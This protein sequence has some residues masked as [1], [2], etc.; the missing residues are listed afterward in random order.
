MGSNFGFQRITNY[1]EYVHVHL[2]SVEVG[3]IRGCDLV[4]IIVVRFNVSAYMEELGTCVMN[5][6]PGDSTGTNDREECGSDAP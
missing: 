6:L 2:V 4:V 1:L 5:E 3:I